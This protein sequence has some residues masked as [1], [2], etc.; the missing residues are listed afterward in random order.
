ML[1]AA[2]SVIFWII[3]LP[4]CFNEPIP[5][6][7]M[8]MIKPFLTNAPAMRPDEVPKSPESANISTLPQISSPLH[9]TSR[10]SCYAF[11]SLI[12]C[13]SGWSNS[14]TVSVDFCW[15]LRV[16]LS[17]SRSHNSRL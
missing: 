9:H 1:C 7:E 5:R 12:T 10:I 16:K 8:P 4:F 11:L 6:D 3:Y 13:E 17:I 14:P 2:P 15:I